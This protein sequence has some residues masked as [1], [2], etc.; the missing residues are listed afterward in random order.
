MLRS[1]RAGARL[2]AGDRQ[3][4]IG[5]HLKEALEFQRKE[6]AVP[7]GILETSLSD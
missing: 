4:D 1:R 7:A 6:L 5:L 2:E 3:L